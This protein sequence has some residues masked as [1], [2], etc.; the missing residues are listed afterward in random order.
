M[1][2]ACLNNH[3]IPFLFSDCDQQ[4]GNLAA[5]SVAMLAKDSAM[6]FLDKAYLDATDVVLE[7]AIEGLD[8]TS[9][10][11]PSRRFVL[12]K[13]SEKLPTDI[14]GVSKAKE[15]LLQLITISQQMQLAHDVFESSSGK[16]TQ[17]ACEARL[18]LASL[19]EATKNSAQTEQLITD[20]RSEK[21]KLVA[22]LTAQL[23]EATNAPKELKLEEER[24][25]KVCSD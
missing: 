1:C 10:R 9:L 11:H 14:P 4:L 17:Q 21:E 23:N 8:A 19:T 18:E 2:T 3:L 22:L 7:K 5:S 24:I 16:K 12:E 25:Q 15:L 6:D 20:R 13:T